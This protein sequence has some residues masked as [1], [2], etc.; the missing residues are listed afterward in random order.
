MMENGDV[1]NLQCPVACREFL[2]QYAWGNPRGATSIEKLS[3][4]RGWVTVDEATD[5]ECI[6]AAN[7]LA[8]KLEHAR[9]GGRQQ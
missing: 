3:T 8:E 4:R 6:E 1:W 2:R 5:A 7:Q 9:R